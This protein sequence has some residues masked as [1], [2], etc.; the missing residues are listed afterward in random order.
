MLTAVFQLRIACNHPILVSKDFQKDVDALE[1]KPAPK[2][3]H[4]DDDNEDDGLADLFQKMGVNA[5]TRCDVCQT[6]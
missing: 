3:K 1:S 2:G 4:A 5:V 6:E